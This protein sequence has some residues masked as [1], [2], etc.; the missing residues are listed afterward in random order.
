MS[1]SCSDEGASCFCHLAYISLYRGQQGCRFSVMRNE[2]IPYH[3]VCQFFTRHLLRR[4]L[5]PSVFKHYA[6]LPRLQFCSRLSSF[7]PR[8]GQS[9][10][11]QVDYHLSSCLPSLPHHRQSIAN[12]NPQLI[13]HRLPTANTFH[14]NFFDPQGFPPFRSIPQCSTFQTT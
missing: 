4:F 3:R 10:L 11:F 14:T 9:L 1:L 6:F 5:S 7:H 13:K 12:P 8:Q 2:T